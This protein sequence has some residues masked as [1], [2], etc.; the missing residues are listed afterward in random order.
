MLRYQNFFTYFMLLCSV[1]IS[2][3][4]SAYQLANSRYYVSAQSK[5]VFIPYKSNLPIQKSSKKIERLLI[6]IHSSSYDAN[7]YFNNAVQATKKQGVDQNTLIIAPQFLYEQKL[8]TT[9]TPN[10][11]LYWRVAPFRGSSKGAYGQT[12]TKVNSHKISINAFSILDS[13]LSEMTAKSRFPNLKE[14][15][16]VGHSAGGQLVQRYSMVGK[17]TPSRTVNIRYV[18]SAPSSYAYPTNKRINAFEKLALPNATDCKKY[19]HWGY[20]LDKPYRYLKN[21]PSDTIR[22]R[23]AKRHV[24]YLVG[25]RDNNPQDQSLGKSCAAMLQGENRLTRMQNFSKMLGQHYGSHIQKNHI[26]RVVNGVGHYGKGNMLSKQGL[27]AMFG[28]LR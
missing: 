14:I 1:F 16:I 25:S 24:F 28:R 2:L 13:L 23:Y 26:F 27:S 17:F 10:K 9:H 5:T 12:N 15:V 22:S 11:M 3:N 21:I 6:A 20:G 8:P 19:N 18:V 7:Q 4:T